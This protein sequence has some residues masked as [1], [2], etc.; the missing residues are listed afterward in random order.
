MPFFGTPQKIKSF[1]LDISDTSIKVL[2]LTKQGGQ[3]SPTAFANIPLF[4]RVINNHMIVSEKKLADNILQAITVARKINT[5]YVICSIPEAKSFVRNV[6]LPRMSEDE[7]DGAIPFELEQDIP[8]PVDQ[9]Y[10]DWQI[11]KQDSSK[12]DLLVTAAPKE[13]VDSLVGSL[14]LAKLIPVALEIESQATAR[15]LIG[16]DNL[17][18]KV[19]I[20]DLATKQTSFIIVDNGIIQYTSS[21]PTAGNAMTE[22]IARNLGLKYEEAERLKQ[23]GGAAAPDLLE[24]MRKSVLP[25]LDSILEEIKNIFRFYSEYNPD[26]KSIETILLCGG[27]AKL[28]GMADYFSGRLN[29]GSTG[30]FINVSLGD[31]WANIMSLKTEQSLPFT[32]TEALGFTTVVG[33]AIRGVKYEKN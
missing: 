17:Q 23:S 18:K 19:L 16:P 3:Y 15:A 22:S 32:P 1:G 20:V 30:M 8:V 5:P 27:T 13:Y 6:S 7:I 2:D 28:A 11:I 14:K 21:I 10:L 29:A 4:D 33:L 25:V 26:H 31:P 24:S 9:V 12:F